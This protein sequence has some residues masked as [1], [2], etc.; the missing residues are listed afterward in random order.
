MRP[1]LLFCLISSLLLASCTSE[2]SFESF[3]KPDFEVAFSFN[4]EDGK[5]K[6]SVKIGEKQLKVKIAH[7]DGGVNIKFKNKKRFQGKK[8]I[9]LFGILPNQ[10]PV[11]QKFIDFQTD[12]KSN[13]LIGFESSFKTVVFKDTVAKVLLQEGIEKQLIE[14]NRN[15]DGIIFSASE[16]GIEV[17]HQPKNTTDLKLQQLNERFIQWQ[18]KALAAGCF[19]DAVK[20]NKILKLWQKAQ[21]EKDFTG[22]AF[23]LNP[24]SNLVEPILYYSSEK[25]LGAEVLSDAFQV[26]IAQK[27]TA[28]CFVTDNFK[29]YF[30]LSGEAYILKKKVKSISENVVVPGGLNVV[31]SKGEIDL[32]EGA[33]ILSFSPVKLNGLSITSSDSS[34]RGFH[35]INAR[36]NSIVENCSFDGLKSLSFEN[37]NLPSAVTFYESPVNVINSKFLN[38]NS[39]DGLNLFR[40]FPFVIDGCTFSNTFSDAFDA[41]FS[42][43][44]INNCTFNQVGND[45][46]DVSGSDVKVE[47]S[48]FFNVAD[49]V[50][51]S[52][53]SSIME[54]SNIVVNGAS[55]AVTAKDNS[56]INIDSS[57]I[58]NA[59]VIFCAFQKKQEFGPSQIKANNIEYSGF[60]K[61]F[62]VEDKSSLTIDG[63]TIEKFEKD[64]KQI[65]YGNEY[66]KA[67]VK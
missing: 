4:K 58:K 19:F 50:L 40:S 46:I 8:R 24:V 66:G 39:E 60:K 5:S 53:E 9:K 29:Q 57:E 48:K 62:L 42:D 61:D 55:L 10:E 25:G 64:V 1:I 17:L 6:S 52:G 23:Y 47:N 22:T 43:G 36:G 44:V 33:F 30:E 2:S 41:D 65:L 49:K 67:T 26:A 7:F 18:S 59:E 13:N 20:T 11:F 15:R 16:D 27:D 63:K 56:S 3:D 34:G 38:N 45:G 12:L 54:V 51:S 35:V 31:I 37:W 14:S 21:I 28:A 32:I